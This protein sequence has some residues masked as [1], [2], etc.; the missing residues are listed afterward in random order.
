MKTLSLLALLFAF[1]AVA[2][3][4]TVAGVESKTGVIS[5]REVKGEGALRIQ[6][7][8]AQ[9]S[10]FKVGEKVSVDR[11]K[12][13]ADIAG[14]VVNWRPVLNVSL[15]TAVV[16]TRPLLLNGEQIASAVIE[17]KGVHYV[18]LED[19]ARSLGVVGT[20]LGP[21]L[22]LDFPRLFATANATNVETTSKVTAVNPTQ[23][24]SV[25]RGGEI[26]AALIKQGDKVYVP[27]RDVMTAFGIKSFADG[28]VKP[29]PITV[30]A[31]TDPAAILR[32]IKH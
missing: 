12:G 29:G 7:E 19:V 24:L 30:T 8:P 17:Q 25:N 32:M 2:D 28:S 31:N 15:A 14:I 18:P 16:P 27:V 22:K 11:N 10:S 21:N 20:T 4:F 13:I 6:V 1:S 23:R 5:L 3:D 26:S 9:S